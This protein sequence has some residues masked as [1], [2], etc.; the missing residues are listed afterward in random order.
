MKM[1]IERVELTTRMKLR[2]GSNIKDNQPIKTR[3][4]LCVYSQLGKE[5]ATV[6]RVFT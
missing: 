2:K 5:W 4:Q 1:D 6:S 3:I